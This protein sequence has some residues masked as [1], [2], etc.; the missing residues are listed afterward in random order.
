MVFEGR[1]FK[2]L[3]EL[4]SQSLWRN[5]KKYIKLEFRPIY[6]KSSKTKIKNLILIASDKTMNLFF[7]K[8][9]ED[10]ENVQFTTRAK[11]SCRFC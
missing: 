1:L 8:A 3:N 9:E 6:H 10:K 5:R 4:A 7:K 11:K 2:D